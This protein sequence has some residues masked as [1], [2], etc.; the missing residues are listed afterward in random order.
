MLDH[1]RLGLMH[2]L[3]PS[4]SRALVVAAAA[5]LGLAGTGCAALIDGTHDVTMDFLV[6]PAGG[7]F[8]GWTQVTL[9][10][11]INT[12]SSAVLDGVTLQV[13]KP[14]G[15]ADLSF[16]ASLTGTAVTPTARTAVVTQ[17]DFPKGQQIVTLN[18]L[19]YGDL[20]PLFQDDHTIRIDWDGAIDP[21]FTAWPSGGI[22]VQGDVQIDLNN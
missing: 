22:W 9:D 3:S 18:L 14:A 1:T 21:S 15:I 20:H 10:Q 2:T 4:F 6:E 11:D 16:L 13:E 12:V 19:Y 7:S 5:A 8:H 17:T